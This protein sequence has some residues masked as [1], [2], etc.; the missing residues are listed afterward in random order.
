MCGHQ[1][2]NVKVTNQV[3]M[4]YLRLWAPLLDWKEMIMSTRKECPPPWTL[5]FYYLRRLVYRVGGTAYFA[6]LINYKG[7]Y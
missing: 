4:P 5:F 1:R 7:K 6:Y 2:L 3:S